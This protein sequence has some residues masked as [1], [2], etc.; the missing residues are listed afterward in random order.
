MSRLLI[1]Y[2][3]YPFQSDHHVIHANGT[4]VYSSRLADRALVAR[5]LSEEELVQEQNA[6]A[7][8]GDPDRSHPRPMDRMPI[9][10]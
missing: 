1:D 8:Q 4:I 3:V 10:V 7:T 6:N 2:V 9:P 5:L